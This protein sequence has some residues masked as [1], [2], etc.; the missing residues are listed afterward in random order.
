M[1]QEWRGIFHDEVTLQT[2]QTSYRF[3]AE[4]ANGAGSIHDEDE[5]T[6]VSIICRNPSYRDV[7]LSTIGVQAYSD[8]QT[9]VPR[10]AF[11][12][13]NRAGDFDMILAGPTYPVDLYCLEFKRIKIRAI[14]D[15]R[16]HINKLAAIKKL[17]AQV[18]DRLDLGFS[19]VSAVIILQGDLI[20]R[21]TGHF[22]S[23]DYA[24]HTTEDF[25]KEITKYHLPK[26]AGLVLIKYNRPLARNAGRQFFVKCLQYPAK[27]EQRQ[28]LSAKYMCWLHY[29]NKEEFDG[30][31]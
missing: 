12:E 2:G 11:D 27:R 5:Q 29:K 4:N 30:G 19:A 24:A 22:H 25:W 10:C 23:K 16:D 6:I 9:G 26:E 31:T 1:I 14:D 28:G 3:F 21:P 17:Y 15:E 18:K 13:G 8:L 7:L 20:A